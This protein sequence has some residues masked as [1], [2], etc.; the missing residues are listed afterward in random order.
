M[1]TRDQRLRDERLMA[2]GTTTS[3]AVVGLV[4]AGMT[5]APEVRRTIRAVAGAATLEHAHWCRPLPG[6]DEVRTESFRIRN[7]AGHL[8]ETWRCLECGA[9][10]TANLTAGG[11][12]AEAGDANPPPRRI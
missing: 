6:D 4:A 12:T 7:D 9:Q 2:A 5:P 3:G 1:T 11:M 10:L 8:F